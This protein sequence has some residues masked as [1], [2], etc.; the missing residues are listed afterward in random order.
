MQFRNND[1]DPGV[2]VKPNEFSVDLAYSRLLSE[3]WSAAV[4]LRYI[5]SDLGGG[6]SNELYAGNAVAADIAVYYLQPLR[7]GAGSDLAVGIDISNIG[8][9][10]SF[11]D[12]NTKDFLPT[13]FRLGLAFGYKFDDYNKLTIMGETNKLLVPC[14]YEKDG[15]LMD[16]KKYS[17]ISPISGIFKSFSDAPD[18]FKEELKEFMWSL[19]L[20][21]SYQDQFFARCGY[22]HE[23]QDKGN[24]KYFTF[25]AGF[26]LNIFE[27]QA[28]YVIAQGNNNP[29][30]K[31]LRFTLGFDMAGLKTLV[32]NKR[33]QN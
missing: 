26:K 31:T 5:R 13:N 33:A 32:S 4:A 23:S 17:D 24:R 14:Q 1:S 9:K 15:T 16:D 12:G 3:C 11:D 6:V 28:A 8:S 10:I 30:D 22:F 27:L 20:E 18:G 19:G 21:Y 2:N 7:C 29:L 25:G